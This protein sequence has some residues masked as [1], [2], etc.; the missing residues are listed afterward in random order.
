MPH[1]A[2]SAAGGGRCRARKPSKMRALLSCRRGTSAASRTAWCP[3][4]KHL[5]QKAATSSSTPPSA[6]GGRRR[7]RP[8][9][10]RRLAQALAEDVGISIG[11]QAREPCAA[12][13]GGAAQRAP[14]AVELLRRGGKLPSA[15]P[16][17][18]AAPPQSSGARRRRRRVVHLGAAAR[19]G[20]SVVERRWRRAP[21]WPLAAPRAAPPCASAMERRSS[22]FIGARRSPPRGR[23]LRRPPQPRERRP[24]PVAAER[25]L[26]PHTLARVG[27]RELERCRL[28]LRRRGAALTSRVAA[29]RCA[30]ARFERSLSVGGGAVSSACV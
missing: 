13:G 11:G 8:R 26:Q 21:P 20:G 5:R 25:R 19:R 16:A 30:A 22:S 2:A 12:I 18:P 29:F 14:L 28:G 3:A 17:R 27:G 15:A 9:S 24:W 4:P 23:P 7:T 10:E 1:D 6:A